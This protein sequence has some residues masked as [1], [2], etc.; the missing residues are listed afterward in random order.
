MTTKAANI[1]QAGRTIDSSGNITADTIDNIDSIQFI[2]SDQNDTSSGNLEF[3]GTGYVKLPAGTTAQRP[4]SPTPG[5]IR[6]NTEKGVLEQYIG[7]LVWASIAPSAAITSVTLPGSQ[8]AVSNG[9]TI[10]IDG[11]GFDS[12]AV[13]SFLLNSNETAATSTTRVNSS[14]LTA[15]IPSLPEGTY[16]VKVTNGTGVSAE[17]VGA[18][19]VDG[20]PVFNTPSGSL[21]TFLDNV[22]LSSA[23][24]VGAN[25][26][27]SAVNVSV[28]SGSLP[29]GLSITSAG[30]ITGTPSTS[31]GIDTVYSITV[32]AT[33]SENQTSS[34]NF[35][36]TIRP[37]YVIEGSTAFN[38]PIE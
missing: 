12:G 21:G 9:D 37:N 20:T 19:D 38:G 15:V 29:A 5:M 11:V 30:S 14:Q 7:D 18:F 4:G 32:T 34:R 27:G 3:T 16:T 6:Y 23:L 36:I 26:D 28:T 24:D 10:T 35:N 22:E 17:L 25:E 1:A 2:R 31:V 13:V 8:T 33:D